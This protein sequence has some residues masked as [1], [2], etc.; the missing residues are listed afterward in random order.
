M[1]CLGF[2][3]LTILEYFCLLYYLKY[4]KEGQSIKR[5]GPA[6]SHA[7]KTSNQ[8]IS[9]VEC[10]QQGANT[11]KETRQ[12]NLGFENED[13]E[14]RSSIDFVDKICLV[15]FPVAFSIFSAIYFGHVMRN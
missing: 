6:S 11:T 5:T 2:V 12:E 8:P 7:M 13:F 3:F 9:A 4:I 1:S 15:I 14:W 10:W